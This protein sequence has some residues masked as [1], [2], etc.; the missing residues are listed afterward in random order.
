MKYNKLNQQIEEKLK[1]VAEDIEKFCVIDNTEF[2]EDYKDELQ[3]SVYKS[4]KS[5]I[6]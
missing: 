6:S 4:I 3:Y 5:I 2:E 1:S